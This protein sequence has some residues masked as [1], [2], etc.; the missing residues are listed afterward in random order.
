MRK[1]LEALEVVMG[2]LNI[3]EGSYNPRPK[4][5]ADERAAQ[6][7]RTAELEARKAR[8]AAGEPEPRADRKAATST[9]IKTTYGGGVEGGIAALRARIAAKT[10]P[11]A[12]KAGPDLRTPEQKMHAAT[13]AQQAV[14]YKNRPSMS[15]EPEKMSG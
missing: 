9:A 6:R 14:K 8:M 15:A 7:A 12:P 13:A 5:T 10:T 4:L 2:S 1:I 3:V 11:E